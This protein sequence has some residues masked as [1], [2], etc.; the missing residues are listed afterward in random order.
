VLFRSLAARIERSWSDGGWLAQLLRPLGALHGGLVALRRW[1][2]RRGLLHSQRLPVPVIVVG[3]RIVGGAGKTPTTLA[4]VDALR[5]AGWHP[6]IVSRGHGG[7]AEGSQEVHPSSHASD[8]G[9]EPLLMQRRSGVPVFVGRR[10]AEAGHALLH[11]HP[12][13]DVIVCDDGLQHLG[14]QRDLEVV[15]FDERGA[16]NRRL[17]PAGPLREPIDAAS[18]AR[19]QWVLYN[20]AQ[21]STALPGHCAQ[22]RL[23]GL[24]T[25]EDWW[26]GA[27][28]QPQ[29]AA[30]LRGRPVWASAGLGQPQRFFQALEQELGLQVQG[31]PLADHDDHR[32]LPWPLD[33]TEVIVTEKDATKLEPQRLA[34]ER[35]GLQVWVAPLLFE[36]PT[37]LIEELLAELARLAP[38][39]PAQRR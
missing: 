32:Q 27:A 9:D 30:A 29:A 5:R 25:L 11:A 3:N 4:L 18:T 10:R 19:R 2:Y 36:L 12:Q 17:L 20:A 16:G 7:S 35:P 23:A 34:R 1:L 38:L 24:L 21:P 31:L 26:A 13:I 28:A 14:L 39:R 15:L 22:R 8:V 37:D 6:G 33:A